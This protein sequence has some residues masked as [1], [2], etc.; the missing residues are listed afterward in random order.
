MVDDFAPTGSAAD[1]QRYHREADRL[2]RTQGDASGRQRLRADSTLKSA[3]PPRGI[4]LSTSEDIPRGQSLRA[5]TLVLE[6]GL[7]DVDWVHLTKCQA[8]A[9]AGLYAEVLA[10]FLWWLAPRYSELRAGLRREVSEL[11]ELSS[12]TTYE[13]DGEPGAA[14]GW[15]SLRYSAG[16]R[17]AKDW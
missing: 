5:R 6:L 4:I 8:A 7:N 16:V 15:H 1:V 14:S 13:T 11:R 17:H 2:L 10:G 12:F 9:A 3:K